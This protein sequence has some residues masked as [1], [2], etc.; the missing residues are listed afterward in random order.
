V[1]FTA[2]SP[3][4]YV[5]ASTCPTT[6]LLSAESPLGKE[7]LIEIKHD[8]FPVIARKAASGKKTAFGLLPRGAG[9]VPLDKLSH[10]IQR[11]FAQTLAWG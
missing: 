10:V 9:E 6:R 8:G 3:Y 11:D 5:V 4:R 1:R 2:L 7:W